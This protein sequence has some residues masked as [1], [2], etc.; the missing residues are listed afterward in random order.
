MRKKLC[1]G[2]LWLLLTL[3]GHALASD[4]AEVGEERAKEL[5]HLLVQECG[6]CHGLEM[7]GGLGPALT[8]DALEERHDDYLRTVILH[9]VPGTPMPGWRGMLSEEE[10]QYLV[11]L[12][13]EGVE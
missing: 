11:D 8:Q 9:G 13:R 3:P 6:S 1:I 5:K 10:A 12:M 4:A 2:G 7:H